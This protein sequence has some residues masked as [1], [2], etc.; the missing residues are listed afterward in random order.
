MAEARGPVIWM[1]GQSVLSGSV[2]LTPNWEGW[3]IHQN[4]AIQKDLDRLE[5]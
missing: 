4:A 2:Q 3:L 5:K 1:T